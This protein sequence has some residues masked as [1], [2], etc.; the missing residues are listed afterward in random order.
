MSDP[1]DYT[2]DPVALERAAAAQ[3]VINEQLLAELAQQAMIEWNDAHP[4]P[5]GPIKPCQRAGL[6]TAAFTALTVFA[7]QVLPFLTALANWAAGTTDT[8]PDLGIVRAAAVALVVAV[9]T[10]GA[11]FAYRCAQSRGWITAGN[12]VDYRAPARR[13]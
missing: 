3:D 11:N 9:L 7:V 8:A 6:V 13:P 1:A 2:V 5:A 12:T 10:G 4:A